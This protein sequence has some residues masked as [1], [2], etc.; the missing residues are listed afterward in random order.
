MVAELWIDCVLFWIPSYSRSV[1]VVWRWEFTAE[2]CIKSHTKKK[3]DRGGALPISTELRWT[4]YVSHVHSVFICS[5]EQYRAWH[6]TY[7]CPDTIYHGF[8]ESNKMN[9]AFG[10][11]E[12]HARTSVY[13]GKQFLLIVLQIVRLREMFVRFRILRCSMFSK[14]FRQTSTSQAYTTPKLMMMMMM[15]MMTTNIFTA[16]SS[17][18]TSGFFFSSRVSTL[19]M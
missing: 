5:S 18:Y 13:I 7:R 2:W 12:P 14:F 1:P 6:E 4:N 9:G 16:Y 15:I 11:C 17:S 3:D 10:D 8:N 19:S